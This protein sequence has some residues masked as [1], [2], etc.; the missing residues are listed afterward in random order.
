MLCGAKVTKAC[1]LRRV[2]LLRPWQ[3]G[4][5]R[6]GRGPTAAPGRLA[7]DTP[8]SSPVQHPEVPQK[9][10]TRTN[11]GSSAHLPGELGEQPAAEVAS[12]QGLFHL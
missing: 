1:P 11:T 6:E 7:G 10:K 3:E 4:I 8:G 2:T 12:L 9:T 5:R